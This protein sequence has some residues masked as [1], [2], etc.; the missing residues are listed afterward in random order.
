MYKKHK[1]IMLPT[2]KAE[3]SL[4]LAPTGKL[5]FFKGFFTQEYLESQHKK[6]NHL[7]IISDEEIKEGDWFYH[8]YGGIIKCT[9]IGDND[10]IRFQGA[11]IENSYPKEAKDKYISKIIAT[12]D[13]SLQHAIDKSPYT[14]EVY[15]LPQIHES[16]ISLYI[17]EY[18]KGNK[19][20]EVE[21]EYEEY[22]FDEEWSDISGAYETSKERI[23]L[24]S[25]NTINIPI[26]KDI[27]Y[28]EAVSLY[29]LKK[30]LFE[31]WGFT[32]DGNIDAENQLKIFSLLDWIKDNNKL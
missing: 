31:R 8:T 22:D 12:T 4:V 6:S 28:K 10:D 1:I 23:K 32:D 16:F 30:Q 24:N 20:K 13:T 27:M 9:G 7:Y 14:M 26:P 25:D 18:N 17:E 29:D 2:E 11:L 5:W 3:D 19:I 15:G 21:I